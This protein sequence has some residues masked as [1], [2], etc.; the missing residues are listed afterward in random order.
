[1]IKIF[2]E[3]QLQEVLKSCYEQ[4][5]EYCRDLDGADTDDDFVATVTTL[6]FRENYYLADHMK[7]LFDEDDILLQL[8]NT[9]E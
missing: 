1:M 8:D 3:Q 4:A 5:V 7:L 9:N 2:C 6:I